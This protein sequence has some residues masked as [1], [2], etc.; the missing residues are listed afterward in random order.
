MD[1]GGVES[2]D[3]GGETGDIG[4]FKRRLIDKSGNLCII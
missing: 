1:T 4:E 2:D 3:L